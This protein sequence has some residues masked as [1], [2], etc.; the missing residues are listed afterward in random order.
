MNRGTK[1]GYILM[2]V[3]VVAPIILDWVTYRPPTNEQL[4][5]AHA[6]LRAARKADEMMRKLIKSGKYDN[7]TDSTKREKALKEDRAFFKMTAR[8]ED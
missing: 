6:N 7:I 2:A 4:E 3:G 1:I 8:F 5:E